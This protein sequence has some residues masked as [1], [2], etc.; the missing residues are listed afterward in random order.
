MVAFPMG[1]H[2]ILASAAPAPGYLTAAAPAGK[3]R[4]ERPGPAPHCSP[5]LR[6]PR[7]VCAFLPWETI[8]LT[9]Q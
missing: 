5:R 7:V 3:P 6:D 2:G 4:R 8:L 1:S 9:S